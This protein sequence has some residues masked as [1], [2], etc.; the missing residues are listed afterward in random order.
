MS[1]SRRIRRHGGLLFP[2]P[3]NEICGISSDNCAPAVDGSK[4]T[5][6]KAADITGRVTLFRASGGAINDYPPL[7]CRPSS[8]EE[9]LRFI[10][11]PGDHVR[12]LEEPHVQVLAEQLKESLDIARGSYD[13]NWRSRR[14]IRLRPHDTWRSHCHVSFDP[15]S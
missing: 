12:I 3:R 7:G 9:V 11:P 2:T 13:A 4:P 10:A 14:C 6:G 5:C 1:V 15:A 8:L